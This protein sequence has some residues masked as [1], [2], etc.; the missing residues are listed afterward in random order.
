MINSRRKFINIHIREID[1]MIK[2]IW[3]NLP[4]AYHRRI[5]I[6]TKRKNKHLIFHPEAL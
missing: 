5:H 2:A 1:P 6:L 3:I 4:H